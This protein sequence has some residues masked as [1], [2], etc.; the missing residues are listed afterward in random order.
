MQRPFGRTSC[1][2]VVGRINGHRF[3][4]FVLPPGPTV[5][6]GG[7]HRERARAG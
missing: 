7:A 3:E 1:V 4:R 6:D 2:L 5:A